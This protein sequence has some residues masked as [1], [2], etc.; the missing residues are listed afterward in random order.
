MAMKEI[1][2]DDR[3]EDRQLADKLAKKIS[4]LRQQIDAVG[5]TPIRQ[6][7][8]ELLRDAWLLTRK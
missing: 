7:L 4:K 2:D 1:R 3:I 6:N 8:D 5:N